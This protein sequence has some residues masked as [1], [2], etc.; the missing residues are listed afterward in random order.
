ME[1][2]SNK[3]LNM[4]SQN[5]A[6]LRDKYRVKEI[7]IFGSVAR[8]EQTASSDVDVLVTFSEPVGFFNFLDLEDF[9]SEMFKKKVDLVTKKALKSV[10]KEQIIKETIY[11]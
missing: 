11:A 5:G 7:G 8:G 3:Y 1:N 10:V 4:L 2:E 9:L 6:I